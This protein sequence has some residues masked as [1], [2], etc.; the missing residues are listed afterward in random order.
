M[1]PQIVRLYNQMPDPKYVISMGAAHFRRAVQA[2]LQRPQRHRPLHSG[3]CLHSRLPA[4]AGSV[5]HA[6]MELQRKIDSQKLTGQTRPS[7]SIR[8]SRANSGA[9]L[10]QHDLEPPR[11]EMSFIRRK[12]NAR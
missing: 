8:R 6:F 11:I 10:W 3:R 5:A 7:F 2:R 1:A 12:S 4:A 9:E